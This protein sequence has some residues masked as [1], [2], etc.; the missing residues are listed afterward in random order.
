MIVSGI[1]VTKNGSGIKHKRHL[2]CLDRCY[3][4]RLVHTIY[5]SDIGIIIPTTVMIFNLV[6]LYAPPILYVGKFIHASIAQPIDDDSAMDKTINQPII[7]IIPLE[8][9]GGVHSFEAYC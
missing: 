8:W 2:R 4:G 9:R 6:E 7:S 5:H 1:V 3:N